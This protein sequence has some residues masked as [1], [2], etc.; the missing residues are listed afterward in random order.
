[1]SGPGRLPSSSRPSVYI[2]KGRRRKV[3]LK[4]GKTSEND[5]VI[6]CLEDTAAG[7]KMLAMPYTLCYKAALRGVAQPG[8]RTC[9]GSRGSEVQILSPRPKQVGW[10]PVAQLDRATDF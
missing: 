6:P 3:I 5:S 2:F 7:E 9:L 10:A 8:E 4:P 1:M